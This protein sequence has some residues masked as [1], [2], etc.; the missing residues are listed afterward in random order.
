MR[1]TILDVGGRWNLTRA[2]ELV[3]RKDIDLSHKIAMRLKLTDRTLIVAPSGFVSI[4]AIRTSFAGVV[5]ILQH[6]SDAFGLGFIFDKGAYFA[7]IPLAGALVV[8]FAS[9]NA[10]GQISNIAIDDCIGLTGDGLIYNC[11]ADLMLNI[12]HHLVVLAFTAG[13]SAQQLFIASATL[14]F[15][16]QCHTERFEILGMTTLKR[17]P[18]A[19]SDHSRT[20]FVA[21][22]RWVNLTWVYADDVGS[23]GNLRL[24]SILDNDMPIVASGFFVEHQAHFQDLEAIDTIEINPDLVVAFSVRQNDRLVRGLE[25]SA[26]P[27]RCSELLC[28]VWVAMLRVNLLERF[29][30]FARRVKTILGG[31]Y[32]V[33]V[34][35]LGLLPIVPV[36]ELGCA[37][38]TRPMSITTQCP[39]MRNQHLGVDASAFQIETIGYSPIEIAMKNVSSDHI[40]FCASIYRLIVASL[41]LPAV[42]AKYERVHSEGNFLS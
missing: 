38:V 26:K 37:E 12:A 40:P 42:A 30:C 33:S 18:F 22:N 5:L 25:R 41:T 4:S 15:T 6:N 21:Y 20:V 31:V 28:P 27:S 23:A 36:V 35:F 14:R 16:G 24:L 9:I 19:T 1:D 11:T 7:V 34:K 29:R 39:P 10:I 17:T 3:R 8:D 2:T 32:G 13:L